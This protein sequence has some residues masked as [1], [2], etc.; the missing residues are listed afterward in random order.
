[1]VATEGGD[2]VSAPIPNPFFRMPRGDAEFICPL[3]GHCR[4]RST[5]TKEFLPH[6]CAWVNPTDEAE[7]NAL[8][9]LHRIVQDRAEREGDI[10][11]GNRRFVRVTPSSTDAG[12]ESNRL[13]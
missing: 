11:C 7:V 8:R 2:G 10:L 12:T 13:A 6:A 9:G 1:M 3:C 4:R 5:K